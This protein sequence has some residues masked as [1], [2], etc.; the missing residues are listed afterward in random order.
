MNQNKKG[1]IPPTPNVQNPDILYIT[2]PMINRMTRH[3]LSKQT[4]KYYVRSIEKLVRFHHLLNPKG[5][6]IEQVQLI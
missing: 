5:M 2:L 3:R 1:T 6:D 4:I